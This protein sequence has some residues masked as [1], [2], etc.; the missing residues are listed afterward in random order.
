MLFYLTVFVV[1]ICSDRDSMSQV[2]VP[3][4]GLLALIRDLVSEKLS[5]ATVLQR[6]V[7]VSAVADEESVEATSSTVSTAPTVVQYSTRG[8]FSRPN[9]AAINK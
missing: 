2:R 1:I 8:S 5:W 9:P 3:I 7:V 6:F 4:S